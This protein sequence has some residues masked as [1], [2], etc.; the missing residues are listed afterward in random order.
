MFCSVLLIGSFDSNV[1]CS[2]VSTVANS[3]CIAGLVDSA[4]PLLARFNGPHGV[5]LDASG[6]I[7]VADSNNN[8][9]RK[10]TPSGGTHGSGAPF[11]EIG[12]RL[13]CAMCVCVSRAQFIHICLVPW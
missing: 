7:I 13:K 8:C 4:N 3:Q 6:N 11:R 10:I 9:F 1:V 2:V 12:S 5:S